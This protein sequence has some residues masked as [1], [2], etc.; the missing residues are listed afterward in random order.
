M[1]KLWSP[2]ISPKGLNL[3]IPTLVT[4]FSWAFCK[5][6]SSF[7]VFSKRSS[8]DFTSF[9]NSFV[10]VACFFFF[11]KLNI[12]SRPTFAVW[13]TLSAKARY[14]G[15]R[16]RVQDSNLQGIAPNGF[17]DHRN[18]R[19]ANPPFVDRTGLEPVTS[20]MPSRHAT[21][22]ANGPYSFVC[23]REESNLHRLVRS[24]L[25]YPLSYGGQKQQ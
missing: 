7:A 3:T 24:E 25:L 18:S 10:V 22:C 14:G 11:P 15:R 12:Y 9:T 17:R 4:A 13:R 21:N 2:P 1:E 6:A 20:S 8:K 23:P 16:R 5:R 19:S